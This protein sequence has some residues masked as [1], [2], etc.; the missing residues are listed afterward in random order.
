MKI[1]IGCDHIVTDTKN[2]NRRFLKTKGHEVTDVGNIRIYAD[3]LSIYG[4]KDRGGSS[5]RKSG[6]WYLFVRY[7]CWDNKCSE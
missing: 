5:T 4:E 3:T 1:V 7:R 2:S 6:F